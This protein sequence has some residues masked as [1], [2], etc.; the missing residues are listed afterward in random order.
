M[1]PPFAWARL[2][3]VC[4]RLFRRESGKRRIV[5]RDVGPSGRQGT[6]GGENVD[7]GRGSGPDRPVEPDEARAHGNDPD[8]VE[9]HNGGTGGSEGDGPRRVGEV[10]EDR[11]EAGAQ[12]RTEGR[13]PLRN[14]D[15]GANRA[16]SDAG[17]DAAT[18]PGSAA[19][20]GWNIPSRVLPPIGSQDLPE[21]IPTRQLLGASVVILATALGS[22][23]FII[24]PYITTQIGIAF[25]WLAAVGVLMAGGLHPDS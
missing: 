3:L 20:E 15:A 6:G 9:V 24:W 1:H 22:G 4:G 23:E 11:G 2:S 25:L 7:S 18:G 8:A 17:R 13:E 14:S 12:G 19:Q 10:R 21:P 5:S 16:T